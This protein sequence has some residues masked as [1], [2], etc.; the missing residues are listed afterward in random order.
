VLELDAARRGVFLQNLEQR[1]Y[2]PG[3]SWDRV[4]ASVALALPLDVIATSAWMRDVM[5]ELRPSG[6]HHLARY[7][8]DK[9]LFGPAV[10][11]ASSGPLRVL[12]EGQ[13]SIWWKGVADAVRAVRAATEDVELTVVALDPAEAGDLDADRILGDLDPRGMARLY[14]ETDVLV[15]LARFEGFG[16][17]PLEAFHLGVPCVVTPYT[18][19]EEYVEHGVNGLVAGLDDLGAVAGYLDLLAR[20]RA[21]LGRLSE[22]AARTAA[23]WPG[24]EASS[25]ELAVAMQELVQEPPAPVE[26]GIAGALRALRLGVELGREAESRV[27]DLTRTAAALEEAQ[28]K[29]RELSLS[30]DE[31]SRLLEEIRGRLAEATSSRAYRA[32]VIARRAVH[33]LRR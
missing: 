28:A 13:P 31:C 16:L 8:I 23:S 9:D 3:E 27:S 18:G 4:G 1:Y 32:A 26:P 12:V 21:L 5:T 14:A 10:R 24:L 6:R 25:D 22:G 2:R 15:K 30:R 33:G 20:D 29:V 11:P 7:G 17:A 19:H